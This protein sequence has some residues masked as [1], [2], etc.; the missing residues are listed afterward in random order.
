MAE[1]HL[2]VEGSSL[3]EIEEAIPMIADQF[4]GYKPSIP[5]PEYNEAEAK[6]AEDSDTEEYTVRKLIPN[7]EPRNYKWT[8][9]A[10]LDN[11][12]G[13]KYSDY[14]YTH[15]YSATIRCYT[16]YND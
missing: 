14:R 9:E 7:P 12:V 13:N 2:H 11:N 3:A 6:K 8:V 5:N 4:F 15:K 10:R 1:L 16:R